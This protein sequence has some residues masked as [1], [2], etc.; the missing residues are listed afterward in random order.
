MRA[1]VEGMVVEVTERE[2]EGRD[3]KRRSFDAYVQQGRYIDRISGP[4]DADN[5]APVEGKRHRFD[6]LVNAKNGQ[7]GPYLSLWAT[8]WHELTD[9]KPQPVKAAG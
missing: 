1:F 3:G 4:V 2:Y 7:K 8:E 6:V 5:V 9:G